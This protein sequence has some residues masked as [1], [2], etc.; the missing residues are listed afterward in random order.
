MTLKLLFQ[1]LFGIFSFDSS[2]MRWFNVRRIFMVL[3]L[4]PVF[5]TLLIIN[6]SFLL[7][8]NL[9]FP[10]F[11][12]QKIKEPVFIIS[13]PRTATTYLFHLLSKQKD[14]YTSIKLW[15]II[16]APS[17]T[18]KIICL[19]VSKA[20]DLLGKPLKRLI[21]FF[22]EKVFKN[23]QSIHLIGLQYPEEDE[24]LLLWDLS[25]AYFNFFY[26][27]SNYF[28]AY[29][30]FDN[31]LNKNQK[32]RIM[33]RYLNYIKR[34]NYVFNKSCERQFLSKNPLMMPK[35]EAL[36]DIL[37]DVKI[38][39]I[40]RCPGDTIPSTILLNN[41]LYS[42]FTSKKT[43]KS[44]NEKT[45]LFLIKWYKNADKHLQTLYKDQ[46]FLVDFNLLVSSNKDHILELLIFLKNDSF[47]NE[48]VNFNKK[49]GRK[50]V[51]EKKYE[52][53]SE[54]ELQLIL[55]EIPFMKGYCY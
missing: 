37:P 10:F 39:S 47:L 4:L 15:E 44:L 31:E 36:Y 5:I 29:F 14:R 19:L 42:F 41:K 7:L 16:F 45:F 38:I 26:P 17:I 23:L 48:V 12:K 2:N 49:E 22:E 54:S 55:K 51:S 27:D 32:S 1:L 43:P 6:H 21:I 50:H 33:R 53:C 8:D 52:S 40:N 9:F 3:F 20:D 28:D 30:D 18:Q 24:A 11:R 46:S 25:T 34:H 13:M 35:L